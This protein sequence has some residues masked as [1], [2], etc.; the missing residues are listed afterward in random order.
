[1]DIV[2]IVKDSG[3]PKGEFIVVASGIMNALGIRES[4][5]ID[6]VVTHNL[7]QILK[8]SGREE[9]DKEDYKVL[10]NGPLEAGLC[11]DSENE[12]P[13]FDNLIKDAVVIND[14]PFAS[15]ERVK[16]YKQKMQRPKDIKDIAL[17]DKY[18]NNLTE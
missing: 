11:W 5:D 12:I 10:L 2:K 9:V 1:M 18:L 6:L 3:L 17:I 15:L 7:Y 4:D 8:Q 14:V 13:N 16:S